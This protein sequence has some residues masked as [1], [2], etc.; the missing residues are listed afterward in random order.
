MSTTTTTQAP[1]PQASGRE[2]PEQALARAQ[3]AAQAKRYGEAMGICQDVL[4]VS[5][6]HPS[7]LALLGVVHAHR[8][9]IERAVELLQAA[10]R[11]NARVAAWH[12]NLCSLLRMLNRIDEA[13]AAGREAV[14]LA[15]DSPDNLVNL[16]LALTDKDERQQ[17]TACL[18]RAI[19]LNDQHAD[20]HLALAQLLLARGEMEPGWLEYEWRNQTEAGKGTLPRITSMPWNGMHIPGGK[21][22]LIGD[23]GYGDTIQF[24]RYIPMAAARCEEVLLGCSVELAPLLGRIPGVS[25]V[26]HRWNEIPG[27]AAYCRLSSLALMFRT[28]LETIPGPSPYLTPDPARVAKWRAWLDANHPPGLPRIG[29]AWTGRPTHPNDRRRSLRLAALAPLAQAARARFISLQ[30]P[31]PAIDQPSMAGF[32]GLADI[33][34]DLQDFDDTAALISLLDLVVT[35]DTSIGHLSGA[36]GRPVW[37]MLAKA[38]DWRW[39]LDRPD[40][41]WYPSA[42]NYSQT[43]AGAWTPLI[44]DVAATL[45]EHVARELETEPA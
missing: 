4:A 43:T 40:T 13:I 24:A 6:E 31:V 33:S 8:G 12:A 5:P 39:L 20:A 27:H 11:K 16:S 17:A 35:I 2:T 1:A 38:S 22:L 45:S 44:E 34:G 18:I 15:P 28:T 21:L 26:F 9:E 37:I 25:R 29:I 3:A 41:P 19:G 10:L 14:R 36:L 23:Q 30:K 42:F 7:A 32:P